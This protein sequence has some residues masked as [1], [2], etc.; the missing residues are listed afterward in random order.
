MI[1]IKNGL[2]YELWSFYTGENLDGWTKINT[3]V[4]LMINWQVNLELEP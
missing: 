4:K 1:F 3:K 2:Q